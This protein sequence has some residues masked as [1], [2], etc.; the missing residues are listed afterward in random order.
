MP[1]TRT[2]LSLAALT[3]ALF[4]GWQGSRLSRAH[5][6]QP[7][8][9]IG[10][11]APA[12]SLA[13]FRAA[14]PR[15]VYQSVVVSSRLAPRGVDIVPFVIRA[16]NADSGVSDFTFYVPAGTTQTLTFPAGWANPTDAV[17]FALDGA[18]FAGWGVTMANGGAPG[19][20]VRFE[21]VERAS[22]READD[23]ERERDFDTF[24]REQQRNK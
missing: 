18:E 1:R 12:P 13:T 3:T 22:N 16:K 23:R 4:A 6:A 5:A 21:R 7:E 9:R 10:P 19:S 20:M 11:K 2:L 8:D 24:L 15:G 14:I 17:L